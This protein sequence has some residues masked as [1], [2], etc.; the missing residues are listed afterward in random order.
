MT[1]AVTEI[2]PCLILAALLGVLAGWLVWGRRT[3]R[4]IAVYRGRLA[5]VRRN[6]E[7]VEERLAGALERASQLERVCGDRKAEIERRETAF[8][9]ILQEKEEGWRNERR[10]LEATVRR[11]DERILSLE[12]GQR[13][14]TRPV[15][16]QPDKHPSRTP[17]P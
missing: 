13:I 7:T 8:Q 2:W 1:Y 17:N 10:L 16:L 15:E 6:W 14:Q 9:S 11:L 3:E 5:K 4:I 12:A